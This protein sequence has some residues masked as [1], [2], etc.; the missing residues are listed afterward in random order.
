[1]DMKRLMTLM[2]STALVAMIALPTAAQDLEELKAQLAALAKK[3]EALEKNAE[4][5]PVVKKAEP[6]MALGT[7]DGKFEMNLRGRIYADTAW[8]SDSDNTMDVKATEFRTARLG[9]EGKA[10]KNVKYKLEADFS[11]NEVTMKVA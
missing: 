3:V 1:M 5:L 2:A 9:I 8:I 4:N 11:G 6:A 10:G 7:K